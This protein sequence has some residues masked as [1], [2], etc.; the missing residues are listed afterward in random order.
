LSFCDP[1]AEAKGA[2]VNAAKAANEAAERARESKAGA[3]GAQGSAV[4][5]SSA[6]AEAKGGAAAAS[7]AS[8]EAKDAAA[9]ARG[10]SAEAKDVAAAAEKL[11]ARIRAAV[12]RAMPR[13]PIGVQRLANGRVSIPVGSVN[14]AHLKIVEVSFSPDPLRSHQP[15][16]A[17]FRVKDTRGFVVRDALVYV[18]G[19]PEG[20]FLP[21]EEKRTNPEGL[22][23]IVLRPTSK[24]V[25][26]DGAHVVLFVRRA[27]R[28]TSCLRASR[29]VALFDCASPLPTARPGSSGRL[30][31]SRNGQRGAGRRSADD[32]CVARPY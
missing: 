6:S 8:T 11:L 20:N 10:A 2:A 19:L 7:S 17:S 23:Q 31:R 25:L 13:R 30:S 16:T 4:A 21:A 18:F 9:A 15:V 12:G 28:P 5:A 3:T 26:K 32:P 29:H 14:P 24:V 22:V 1:Q 27:T